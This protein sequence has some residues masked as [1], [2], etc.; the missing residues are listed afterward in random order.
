MGGEGAELRAGNG[1]VSDDGNLV[2]FSTL[3]Y[4]LGGDL[5]DDTWNIY[6]YDVARRHLEHVSRTP[7]GEGAD[8]YSIS[9]EISADGRYIAYMSYARNLTPG[10]PGFAV[11]SC[12]RRALDAPLRDQAASAPREQP[13][14]QTVLS[15]GLTYVTVFI[16]PYSAERHPRPMN[17]AIGAT[18]T[19]MRRQGDWWVTVVGDVPPA[20][21]KLF[22]NGLE[23]K[24]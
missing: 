12:V 9:P 13:L 1:S 6:L 18:Q 8:G 24:K 22:A 16:E 4:N 7:S 2:A 23:R 11:V 21:L 5:N 17:A 10:V 15:D 19:L 3:A 14:L 20:T